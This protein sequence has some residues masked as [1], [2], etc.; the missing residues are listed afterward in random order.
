M[1][2]I[3]ISKINK[4]MSTNSSVLRPEKCC[5]ENQ[6]DVDEFE[7]ARRSCYNDGLCWVVPA[8]LYRPQTAHRITQLHQQQH[9]RLHLQQLQHFCLMF[10]FLNIC[11]SQITELLQKFNRNIF[12]FFSFFPPRGGGLGFVVNCNCVNAG[13]QDIHIHNLTS[14]WLLSPTPHFISK[15]VCLK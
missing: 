7:W 10:Y 11:T 12:V 8:V 14:S 6:V 1:S 15:L 4:K 9:T 13:T 3:F 2:W 5:T